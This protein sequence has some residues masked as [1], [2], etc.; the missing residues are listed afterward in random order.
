MLRILWENKKLFILF[1]LHEEFFCLKDI[2]V[3][4]DV[5]DLEVP[6]SANTLPR[7]ATKEASSFTT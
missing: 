1:V 4:V 6:N 7:T 3:E 2:V 5:L